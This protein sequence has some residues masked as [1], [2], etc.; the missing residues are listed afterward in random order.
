MSGTHE[1]MQE[2]INKAEREGKWLHCYYQDLWFSPADLRKQQAAGSFR[3]G[4]VNWTLRDPAERVTQAKKEAEAAALR[5]EKTK[6]ELEN[7]RAWPNKE[8]P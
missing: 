5:Y 7:G 3:W 8:I 2:L 1:A 4:P 6:Q